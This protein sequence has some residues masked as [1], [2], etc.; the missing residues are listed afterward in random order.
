[1]I[2]TAYPIVD[3]GFTKNAHFVQVENINNNKKL[4]IFH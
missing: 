3:I 4:R 2:K 1:M